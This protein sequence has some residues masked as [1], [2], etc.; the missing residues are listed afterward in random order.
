MTKELSTI[1]ALLRVVFNKESE[2]LPEAVDW[3]KVIEVATEQGVLGVCFPALDFLKKES[4]TSHLSP[5]TSYP[6]M[7]NLMDWLGQTEY[8][9]TMYEEHRNA[10]SDLASFY[11][12][13]AIKM[14]LMKG[15]G[16]S[17]DYPV[18]EHRPTGDIDVYLFG[19]KEF[20]DQMVEQKLGIPVERE[21]HKHSHFT[22]NPSAG[23]GT[24]VTVEN[25]EKFIDDVTHKSN[26]RFEEILME[27]MQQSC[28]SNGSNGL[29]KSPIPNCY[30]PSVTWNALFLL[31]HAGEH[32]AS[33]E[34]TLRHVLDL[35]TFYKA[36]HTEIDWDKV[37]AI[38][39]DE[40][41]KSFYDAIATICVRD[42][43]LDVSYFQGYTHNEN[44]ADRVLEDIFAK[45]DI[46]P[47]SS[48]G[49]QGLA[50]LKYGIQKSLRWW[51]NRWKYKM[52]YKESML[53]SFMGLALNRIKN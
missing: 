5:L 48:A 45:K 12:S 14:M 50:K 23:S 31:R 19:N 4:L 32:F 44:L 8:G 38:Y 2:T 43:G 34:I 52:V 28:G 6:D 46:L 17:L 20:A 53:E 41:M 21:Y 40:Q 35:G 11:Q 10:I 29:I 51:N 47:M 26:V 18:P 1:L 33:N 3:A 37:L 25:H 13:Q 7:D 30:L 36:Y 42:L 9:K 24:A 22:Y 15:Y 39:K 27:V 49:I 16:L